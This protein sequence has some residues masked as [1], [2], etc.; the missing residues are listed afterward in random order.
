MGTGHPN[1]P[2]L[3]GE[4]NHEPGGDNER[5]SASWNLLFVVHAWVSLASLPAFP[6]ITPATSATNTERDGQHDFDFEIGSW[7]SQISRRLHP[8]AG[9]TTCI[10]MEAIVVVRK[11]WNGRA[12][13]MELE[14]DSPTGHL[15]LNLRLYNPQSHQWTF[16]FSNSNDG[17]MAPPMIGEFKNGRGEFIDQEPF[18]GKTILVRRVFT[19]ITPDSH[20][21]EQAFSD[22]GGKNWEPNFMA[23][24]TRE[25]E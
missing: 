1:W 20:H 9:S 21:F 17:T 19:E 15:E 25:K 2:W 8:V 18:N 16:N 6:Q 13:L 11:V 5:A 12:N 4:A 22:D 10:E 23:T 3:R 14:L 7:K 24:L